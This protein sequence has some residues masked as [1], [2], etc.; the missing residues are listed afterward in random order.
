VIRRVLIGFVTLATACGGSPAT[1]P[2]PEP[3]PP[4]TTFEEHAKRI[5]ELA[6]RGCACSDRR[7]LAAIDRDLADLVASVP[8]GPVD[9][10]VVERLLEPSSDALERLSV[11]MTDREVA[12]TEYGKA[13]AR[14]FQ[15]MKERICACED[16]DCAISASA[17][18]L[19]EVT[20]L[21]SF[22]IEGDDLRDIYLRGAETQQCTDRW[23]ASAQAFQELENLRAAACA[24]TDAECAA[25]VQADFDAFLEKH[26]DTK[27][28]KEGAQKLGALAGAMAQ[29]LNA[30]KQ[31]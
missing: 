26:K 25:R 6:T 2:P 31:Q 16:S 14:R 18:L 11:C 30:A 13:L 23:S 22:P 21:V 7:C 17:A 4:V 5:E 19:P 1:A 27:G 15:E 24:C 3:Q 8:L 20:T 12:S 10:A 29:C 9:K 28:S